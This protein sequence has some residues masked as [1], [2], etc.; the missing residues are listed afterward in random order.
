M[1]LLFPFSYAA[2]RH[3]LIGRICGTIRPLL[4]L[5]KVHSLNDLF[6]CIAQFQLSYHGRKS[7]CPQPPYERKATSQLFACG[8]AGFSDQEGCVGKSDCKFGLSGRSEGVRLDKEEVH[9]LLE[10][11]Q[12][13]VDQTFTPDTQSRINGGSRPF[14]LALPRR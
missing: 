14:R 1:R 5:C 10:A 13:L 9:L 11:F 4:S 2:Y 12:M 7:T 8:Y 3:Q 6:V